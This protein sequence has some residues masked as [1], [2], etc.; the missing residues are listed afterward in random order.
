MS[1]KFPDIRVSRIFFLSL[2]LLIFLIIIVSTIFSSFVYNNSRIQL[3]ESLYLQAQSINKILPSLNAENI[4]FDLIAD[5]LA[6]E[7]TRTNKLRITLIDSNWNVIGDSQVNKM[8]LSLVEKHSPDN[9]IE[10]YN[11]LSNDFGSATR[12]S[13][14]INRELIYVAIMRDKNDPNQG[15]IRLSLPFDIYS[16]FFNFFVYP[17]AI[18]VVL[19]IA[20]SV[21]ISLN[22]ENT[23][24]NDLTIL[25][26]NTQRALKGKKFKVSNSTDTQVKS[27]SNVIEEISQ[28]LSNEIEQTL[29]QRTKFGSVLDSINQGIII[30]NK[31]FRVKFANDIALEMFGKHQF[32]LGEKITSK[33]LSVLNKTIKE[34]KKTSNAERE[35]SINIKNKEMHF[36]LS[37]SRM[38]STDEL[39]L[40]I[41]D[42]SSLKKL[43][44]RRKN[45]IS[46]ISHEIKTPISVIR[47]GS[48]TLRDGA[49]NDPKVAEKFLHS[50]NSNS[51]RLAEMID[52][53]LE[54]EKIEVGQIFLKNEKIKLKEEIDLIIESLSTLIDEKKLTVENKVSPNYKFKSDKQSLRDILINLLNNAVKYSK[55]HG[56]VI[57]SSRV[58]KDFLILEIKDFGYGIE[59]ANIKRIFDRFYRTAKARANT[60]GTGLGLTLVNQLV[61]RIGGE[62][63]VESTIG[64]GSTFFIKFPFK[65]VK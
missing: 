64:K 25:F 40:L 52:D 56:R 60:K 20:S 30:F 33:K 2:S 10:I 45:L 36:L 41:N 3:I 29:E 65:T 13:E 51:E 38:D 14:T 37:A 32:F 63:S 19:V 46:D 22:V 24:R 8:D 5:S 17:F 59:K 58:S 15:I 61:K 47:A 12:N 7:D 57:L 6:V 1:F 44:N 62:I 50:I 34:A 54:L 11:A 31:N 4:D 49:I 42:I 39:I 21:F 28:R 16:S 48:E 23:F 26:K 43:E 55:E 9:R 18:I 27:I 53:L 35:F